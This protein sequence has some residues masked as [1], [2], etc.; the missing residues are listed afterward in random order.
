MYLSIYRQLCKVEPQDSRRYSVYKQ[1]NCLLNSVYKH[2][3]TC[4]M[5]R[6]EAKPKRV[7]GGAQI[8]Q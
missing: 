7:S 2:V 6:S 1:L 3:I 8:S 5:R 4:F